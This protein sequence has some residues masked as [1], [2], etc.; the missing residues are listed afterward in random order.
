[1][2]RPITGPSCSCP[3]FALN[4]NLFERADVQ[5]QGDYNDQSGQSYPQISCYNN[6]FR[7]GRVWTDNF[8][9]NNYV[10]KDNIFD[11]ITLM[12]SGYEVTASY[13]AYINMGTNRFYP[14]SANDQVLTSCNYIAGP[15]G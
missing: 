2:K 13:N 4:N 7:Y 15:S 11:S 9:T 12:E 6:L 8:G 5:F 10:F 3:S 14:T 1:G